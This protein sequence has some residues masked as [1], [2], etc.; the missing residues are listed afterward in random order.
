[1]ARCQQATINFSAGVVNIALQFRITN[2]P[3]SNTLL[4]PTLTPITCNDYNL[5]YL[6]ALQTRNDPLRTTMDVRA[7]MAGHM[8]IINLAVPKNVT[9]IYLGVF[10]FDNLDPTSDKSYIIGVTMIQGGKMC[11]SCSGGTSLA[12]DPSNPLACQCQPCAEDYVGGTCAIHL[13][14]MK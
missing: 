13:Q 7:A 2:M 10:N 4:I 1:M 8:Q 11:L 6:S 14:T 3:F 12:V 9:A 5:S